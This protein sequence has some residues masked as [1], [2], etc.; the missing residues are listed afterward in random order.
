MILRRT[1]GIQ[2]MVNVREGLCWRVNWINGTH[3]AERGIY[4]RAR[5]AEEQPSVMITKVWVD[6]V[7]EARVNVIMVIWNPNR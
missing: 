1:R 3:G 4:I 5:I 7:F 6:V 2:Q